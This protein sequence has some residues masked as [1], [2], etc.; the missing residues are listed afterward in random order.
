MQDKDK[1]KK[2]LIDELEEIRNQFAKFGSLHTEHIQ[3]EKISSDS[4]E[5][6]EHFYESNPHPMWI[7]DLE[8]LA[9]LDVNDAGSALLL[10]GGSHY[11]RRGTHCEHVCGERPRLASGPPIRE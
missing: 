3:V 1:T 2:Q 9:F 4:E 7:Y 8:T 6:C 11:H 10:C 5:I